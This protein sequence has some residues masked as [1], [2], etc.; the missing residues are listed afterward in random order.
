[1]YKTF[2]SN[3]QRSTKHSIKSIT[4]WLYAI[5]MKHKT[6]EHSISAQNKTQNILCSDCIGNNEN[7]EPA[8]TALF[9]F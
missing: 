4:N 9:S 7:L 6:V 8:A 2:V 3:L 1:M 5:G